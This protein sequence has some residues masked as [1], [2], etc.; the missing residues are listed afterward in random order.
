MIDIEQNALRSFEQHAFALCARVIENGPDGIDIG[1]DFWGDLYELL[2]EVLRLHLRLAMAAP[3]RIV[4]LQQPIDLRS[5]RV[6][7][8]KILH[9]DGPPAHLVLVSRADAAPGGAY[10]AVSSRCLAHLVEFAVKRQD[11]RG[12]FRNPQIVPAD[13]HALRFELRDF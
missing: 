3:Q 7:V 9:A 8:G 11:Q 12:I 6:E 1:S 4:M 10:P 2:Y 13:V 5:D